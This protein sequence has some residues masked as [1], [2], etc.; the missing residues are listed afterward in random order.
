MK[1]RVLARFAI[2]LGRQAC[3]SS[4]YVEGLVAGITK[5]LCGTNDSHRLYLIKKAFKSNA[6]VF[7][8]LE[9]S[10]EPLLQTSIKQVARI[11]FSVFNAVTPSR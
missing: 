7:G 1:I 11:S 9:G 4:L 10:D 6:P 3:V 5:N 2:A 8:A